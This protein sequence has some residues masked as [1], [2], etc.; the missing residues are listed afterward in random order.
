[1]GIFLPQKALPGLKKYKYAGEDHSLVS[2]YVL[3]P[4]YTRLVNYLPM[5]LAPNMVTLLGLFFSICSFIRAWYF[6]PHFNNYTTPRWVFFLHAFDIIA[7]QTLDALDGQQA[8]RTGSSSPLGELFDHCVDAINTSLLT[9]VWASVSNLP[10]TWV[11]ACEF[12]CTLNFIV[13]TWEEYHTKRLFLSIFSG[14]VEG[15]LMIAGLEILVGF[16]GQEIFDKPLFFGYDFRTVTTIG[17]VIGLS[18]NSKEAVSNV[19]KITK[20]SSYYDLAPFA[21]MWF[22]FA[23]WAYVAWDT[24]E[25]HAFLAFFL[26]IAFTSALLVGRIITAHVTNQPYPMWNPLLAVPYVGAI[27]HF[28]RTSTVSDSEIIWG[29]SGLSLGVYAAF[30]AEIITEI[31]TYLDIACLYIKRKQA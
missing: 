28:L 20:G 21:V 30:V 22:G 1:M 10:K 29:L 5:W 27:A 6:N 11:L 13:S 2:K 7:Y 17:A 16:T 26:A 3:K 18:Y 8:R 12:L 9:Y 31:T 15:V 25:E 23:S 19:I 14:P 24:V 4:T